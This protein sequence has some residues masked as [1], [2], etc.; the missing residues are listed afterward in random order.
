M[1]DRSDWTP[2]NKANPYFAKKNHVSLTKTQETKPL[3][4]F[5]APVLPVPEE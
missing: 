5:P 2:R 1:T 3:V 4:D